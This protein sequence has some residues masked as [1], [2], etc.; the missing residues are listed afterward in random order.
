ME[1]EFAVFLTTVREE[2][3]HREKPFPCGWSYNDFRSSGQSCFPSWGPERHRQFTCKEK[4][5]EA[6]R[7]A[8]ARAER[9]LP[10]CSLMLRTHIQ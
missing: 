10:G 1:R 7:G 9:K 2:E 4:R 8:A 3:E 5:G 6:Q